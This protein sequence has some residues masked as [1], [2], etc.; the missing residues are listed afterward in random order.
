MGH[1]D[2]VEETL[3]HSLQEEKEVKEIEKQKHFLLKVSH[4]IKV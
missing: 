3:A 2:G 4:K 1:G